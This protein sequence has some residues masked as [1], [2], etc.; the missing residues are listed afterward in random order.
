[1]T[2]LPNVLLEVPIWSEVSLIRLPAIN[3]WLH[4]KICG[5]AC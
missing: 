2:L 4:S 1:M 3:N 5:K